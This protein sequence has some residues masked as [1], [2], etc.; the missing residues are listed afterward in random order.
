M[1]NPFILLVNPWIYDFAAYDL[2]SK[3][4]GLLYIAALLKHNGFG[5]HLIDC[6]DPIHPLMHDLP[7]VKQPARK[8]TGKGHFYHQPALKPDILQSIKNKRYKRFGIT[9]SIFDESVSSLPKPSLILV[10][11]MMTYWYPGAF[12]LISRLKALY[13]DVPVVLGGVYATICHEHALRFSGAD[14]IVCGP[15][16]AEALRIVA[17]LFSK[18]ISV[19]PDVHNPD[20]LPCPAHEL[21]SSQTALPMLT[22]RGCPFSCTYCASSLL[23]AGFSRKN[24]LRVAEEIEHCVSQYGTTD[25]AFYDDAFLAEPEVHA[26]PILQEIIKRGFNIR[27]HFPNG[28]HIRYIT[29]EIADLM[30][31]A[32][33]KTIRLGFETADSER[34]KLTGG[35]VVT[36]EFMCAAGFLKN[37]GFTA[38]EAGVYI[39][40]G[41]PRQDASEVLG[42]IQ[43]VKAAGLKPVIAEYSPIPGTVLWDRAV[44]ASPFPIAEEPLFHNNTLLPCQWEKFTVQDLENLKKEARKDLS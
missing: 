44:S 6:L 29:P 42:T 25:F 31:A 40:A 15:G 26:R 43:L 20:S 35:K 41:L 8:T 10:T 18:K 13:P 7:G 38:Q 19:F 4:L 34:Q 17:K 2:W 27:L 5:V 28:L 22:A 3:P 37:A 32:G 39:L 33:C 9:T 11:S 12:E 30:M 14:Y 16:E 24:P 21:L 36:E 23:F 1:S